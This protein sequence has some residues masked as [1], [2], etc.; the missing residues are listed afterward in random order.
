MASL[1]ISSRS[2]AE[3]TGGVLA[4]NG[5]V[6][7]GMK[8]TRSS[9]SASRASVARRRCPTWGGSN[10]PPKTPIRTLLS[11]GCRR[12]WPARF[13][14]VPVIRIRFAHGVTQIPGVFGVFDR[15]VGFEEAQ[16]RISRLLRVRML[17]NYV[18]EVKDRRIECLAL[19]VKV[20]RVVIL[21]G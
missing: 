5:W 6:A 3:A 20:G 8:I 14:Y 10:V 1:T 9:S 21:F 15:P 18:L 4:L 13:S 2:R 12:R 16:V 19:Q 17:A 11:R 7:A